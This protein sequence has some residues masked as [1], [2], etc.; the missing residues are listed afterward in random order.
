MKVYIGQ[1]H[2]DTVAFYEKHGDPRTIRYQDTQDFAESD[3]WHIMTLGEDGGSVILSGFHLDDG[4]YG[5]TRAFWN[6]SGGFWMLAI[7]AEKHCRMRTKRKMIYRK[8]SKCNHRF[9][10]T[11]NQMCY[12]EYTCIN[13]SFK[14]T[15]D[16]SD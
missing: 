13:C 12:K 3:F 11:K 15:I 16:S 9:K 4:W 5:W 2:E 1:R 7:R 6:H 8:W 14:Q 10:T